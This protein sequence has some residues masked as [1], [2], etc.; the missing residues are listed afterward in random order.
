MRI[1]CGW[2][3]KGEVRVRVCDVRRKICEA[4]LRICVQGTDSVGRRQG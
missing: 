1:P 3:W 2:R 4:R